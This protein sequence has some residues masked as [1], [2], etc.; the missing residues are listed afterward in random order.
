MLARV[1]GDWG[2]LAELVDIFRAEYPRLLANL[3]RSV[4]T[5]DARGVQEAAHAIK[6][7]V[8]NFGAQ[9]ASDAAL[10]LEVMGEEGALTGAGAAVARLEREVE[11]LERDLV[12]MG[13]GAPA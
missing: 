2:L 1:E 5:G 9:A 10:A 13:E 6:G 8:G 11:H 12:R 3:R 4:E 7:T